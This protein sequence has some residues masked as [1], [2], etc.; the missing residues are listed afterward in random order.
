MSCDQVRTDY[1]IARIMQGNNQKFKGQLTQGQIE[2]PLP[3]D[4]I[5]KVPK[6]QMHK[7]LVN[8][9][10]NE[11]YLASERAFLKKCEKQKA[12]IDNDGLIALHYHLNYKDIQA[13]LGGEEDINTFL[14][15][16]QCKMDYI[17]ARIVND[18]Q[19]WIRGVTSGKIDVMKLKTS[20]A[21]KQQKIKIDENKNKVKGNSSI[22]NPRQAKAVPHK[23]SFKGKIKLTKELKEHLRSNDSH[24]NTYDNLIEKIALVLKDINDPKVE[25]KVLS[26][27][28]ESQTT[29]HVKTIHLWVKGEKVKMNKK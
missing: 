26:K 24:Q 16:D 20:G 22:K 27:F 18:N 7:E 17:I 6:K 2:I 9:K 23:S 10:K 25:A 12:Q 19:A 13:V 14:G 21:K 29:F 5:R 3:E 8:L 1:Y 28:K 15:S 11:Q 4:E